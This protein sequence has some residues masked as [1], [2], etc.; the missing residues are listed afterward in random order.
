MSSNNPYGVPGY[1]TFGLPAGTVRGFMSLLIVSFFWIVLLLPESR[2]IKTP[3]G[4]FVLLF[5]VFLAFVS[6]QRN[7]GESRFLPWL[8]RA[9]VVGGSVAVVGFV[10]TNDP[11]RI[12]SRFTPDPAELGMW[13]TLIGTMSAAFAGGMFVRY[14][15]GR[16]S[17]FYMAVRAWVGVAGLLLLIGETVFQFAIRPSMNQD[18]S[19]EALKVW[20]AI[21]IG[22]VSSYFGTRA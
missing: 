22:F 19:P 13:P 4:H 16:N 11:S 10:L 7:E 18:P 6:H 5:L 17:E 9:L 12:E 21:L 15:F 2:A 1:H 3:V 20:E 14:V 8:M